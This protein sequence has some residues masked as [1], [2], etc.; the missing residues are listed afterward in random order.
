VGGDDERLLQGR[1]ATVHDTRTDDGTAAAPI[2]PL[3]RGAFLQALAVELERYPAS[4]P[5]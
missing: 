4:F 1:R 3:Q 5:N 2:H